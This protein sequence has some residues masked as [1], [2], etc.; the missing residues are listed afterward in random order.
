MGAPVWGGLSRRKDEIEADD[1]DIVRFYGDDLL[2]Q[3]PVE[4]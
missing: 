1:E 3:L 2:Q 4:A